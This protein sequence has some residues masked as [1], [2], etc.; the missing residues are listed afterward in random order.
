MNMI[1]KNVQVILAVN[2]TM[3]GNEETVKI[4]WYGCPNHHWST[5][6]HHCGKKAVRIVS[7]SGLPPH[8]NSPCSLEKRKN[9]LVGEYSLL[10]LVFS[11]ALV[12]STPFQ[13]LLNVDS[14]RQR[15][16]DGGSSMISSFIELTANSF[17]RNWTIQMLTQLSSHFGC[18]SPMLSSHIAF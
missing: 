3:E 8:I 15:F 16:P 7:F 14:G 13:P 6:V 4:S 2:P 1:S 12:I 9:G 10:L 18:S 5:S 11:P 17:G